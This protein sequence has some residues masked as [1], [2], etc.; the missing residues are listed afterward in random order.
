MHKAIV[1]QILRAKVRLA[2]H[3]RC[4]YIF[5]LCFRPQQIHVIDVF[6]R[7]FITHTYSACVY[8]I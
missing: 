8:C 4:W 5:M 3:S 2:K 6:V 7:V 1:V